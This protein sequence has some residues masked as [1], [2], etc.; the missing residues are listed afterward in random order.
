MFGLYKNEIEACFFPNKTVIQEKNKNDKFVK[1][2]PAKLNF[3]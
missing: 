3:T 2:F 1:I